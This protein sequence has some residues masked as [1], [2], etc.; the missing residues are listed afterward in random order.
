MKEESQ[1]IETSR[2]PKVGY[3][4]EE[5]KFSTGP[6]EKSVKYSYRVIHKYL[7]LHY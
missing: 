6:E 2:T 4:S 5:G 7:H 1:R 3:L